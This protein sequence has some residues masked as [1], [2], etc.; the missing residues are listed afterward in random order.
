MTSTCTS[1][2]VR[3]STQRKCNIYQRQYIFYFKYFKKE[4]CKE[5]NT[6]IKENLNKYKLLVYRVNN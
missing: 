2:P 1:E 4:S 6:K 3:H 5:T